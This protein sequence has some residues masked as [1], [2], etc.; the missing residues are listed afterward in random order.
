MDTEEIIYQAENLVR[1]RQYFGSPINWRGKVPKDFALALGKVHPE[2]LELSRVLPSHCLTREEV[3]AA[4]RDS[5]LSIEARFLI[6][7]A[8]GGMRLKH[9]STAWLAR[10]Q[11]LSILEEMLAG[12]LC[13]RREIY[14]RFSN[15]CIAGLGPAYFTKLMYFFSHGDAC[16]ILDQW[17]ARS[18]NLLLS[19]GR[20]VIH[21]VG[22]WVSR[23]NNACG[24]LIYCQLVEDI[25]KLM[26]VVSADVEENM[27]A[28]GG[29]HPWRPYV[30][31]N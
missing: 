4:C 22:G 14:S 12:A 15:A 25:A 13:E 19:S 3:M 24:Y 17:T 11:W 9:A 30:R 29:M 21:M 18:T 8:W 31:S 5:R 26:G 2:V 27:F 10:S 16:Y 6:V 28:G 7:V 20:P 23:K 1:F